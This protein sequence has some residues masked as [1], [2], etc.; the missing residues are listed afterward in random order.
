[1]PLMVSD[2][3]VAPTAKDGGESAVTVGTGLLGA[4][5]AIE[6]LP[7]FVVSCVEV[8]EMV[9][10]PAPSGVKTPA[11]LTAPMLVGLT[12]HVTE[13]L[14]LPVPLTVGKQVDVCV[15]RI[16]AG[17]QLTVTDV[18]VGGWE[19]P[20]EF[21]PPLPQ[22][23]SNMQLARLAI[24]MNRN[25]TCERAR[26][27]VLPESRCMGAAPPATCPER[28]PVVWANSFAGHTSTVTGNTLFSCPVGH[29]GLYCGKR[30]KVSES[31]Y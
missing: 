3:G 5:I 22:L 7:D 4:A 2:C 14:K 19:P 30:F 26:Q 13:A 25:L 20:P 24:A 21:P 28:W 11:L 17:E 9:A 16:E 23:E 10:V 18:I 27:K 8:A 31:D 15:V 29:G 1:M 6:A 12:D